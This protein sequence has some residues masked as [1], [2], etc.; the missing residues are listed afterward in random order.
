VLQRIGFE[1]LVSII[2]L[3]ILPLYFGSRPKL[4]KG[5]TIIMRTIVIF[6]HLFTRDL[7]RKKEEGKIEPR[8]TKIFLIGL[9]SY[10]S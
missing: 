10:F 5:A 4:E 3:V 2:S 1:A 9:P 7:E 6:D 8:V